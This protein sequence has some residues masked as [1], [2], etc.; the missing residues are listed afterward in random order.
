MRAA[1][2]AGIPVP[3]VF[4]VD[5]A[6]MVM[7]HLDGRSMLD[8]LGRRPWRAAHLG[9]QLA[10]LHLA[11][12]AV[13]APDGLRGSGTTLVHGDLHPGN[14]LM[15]ADGPVIIDWG[16]ASAGAPDED[17][18]EM[19]LL[20]E[21]A[22]VDDL[23]P[24]MR[25]VVGIVRRRMLAAFIERV[26]RPSPTTLARVCDDRLGDPNTRPGERDRIRRLRP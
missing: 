6:D 15:S 8:E 1:S 3:H 12:R 14:V 2:V 18:A 17:A 26:G 13:P 22:E 24:L 16:G 10:D 19:W 5:G 11:L 7:Q 4:A 21:V 9:R 23:S 20:A 25:P